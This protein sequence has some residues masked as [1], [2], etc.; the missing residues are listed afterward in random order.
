MKGIANVNVRSVWKTF[1]KC[2]S[3]SSSEKKK[4]KEAF[5]YCKGRE[6]KMEEAK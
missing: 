6:K 2:L 4:R 5:E 1:Q 3:L